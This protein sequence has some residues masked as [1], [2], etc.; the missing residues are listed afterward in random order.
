MRPIVCAWCGRAKAEV[1]KIAR[2]MI[3]GYPPPTASP[4]STGRCSVGHQRRRPLRRHR[5]SYLRPERQKMILLAQ[6]IRKLSRVHDDNS[7][8]QKP[9]LSPCARR[10]GLT[11]VTYGLSAQR[12]RSA[13]HRGY[14]D[15][16]DVPGPGYQL[17]LQRSCAP[18][19]AGTMPGQLAPADYLGM[20]SGSGHASG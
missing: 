2:A 19:S 14:Q 12:L 15:L 7:L 1:W 3:G 17:A 13:D 18:Q 5:H 9:L 6:T 16:A 4:I 8:L 20:R 11:G 10:I